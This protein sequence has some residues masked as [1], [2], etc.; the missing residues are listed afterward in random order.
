MSLRSKP[1]MSASWYSSL[2]QRHAASTGAF[3]S[4]DTPT[5]SVL[6]LAIALGSTFANSTSSD[7]AMFT[8]PS[9]GF[10]STL[11]LK[12]KLQ[13]ALWDVSDADSSDVYEA[14][15]PSLTLTLPLSGFTA[16]ENTCPDPAS[17]SS[18]CDTS[19]QALVLYTYIDLTQHLDG[20]DLPSPVRPGTT[21]R[22]A[23][24]GIL[25]A[26][27]VVASSGDDQWEAGGTSFSSVSAI[28][29]NMDVNTNCFP[30]D[31]GWATGCG[32]NSLSPAT[33]HAD[34]SHTSSTAQCTHATT[35]S[36]ACAKMYIGASPV[37]ALL[38]AN[39]VPRKTYVNHEWVT[40]TGAD[41]GTILYLTHGQTQGMRVHDGGACYPYPSCGRSEEEAYEPVATW[42]ILLIVAGALCVALGIVVGWRHMNM[43]RR[44]RAKLQLDRQLFSMS[45]PL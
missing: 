9:T 42:V 28:M 5:T 24:K 33:T 36:A 30:G 32:P 39:K 25:N 40:N 14:G 41:A 37:R 10:V 23:S 38:F 15:V 34:G 12:L 1:D 20:L 6:E 44:A 21:R 2:Q 45:Q 16:L 18:Q 19:G 7:I 29:A 13:V 11:A 8:T 22:I 35:P 3:P 26:Q 43:K 27:F 17:A 4:E 31:A